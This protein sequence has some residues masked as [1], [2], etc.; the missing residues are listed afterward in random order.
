MK[1]W[2]FSIMAIVAIQIQAADVVYKYLVVTSADGTQ[3]SLSSSGLK[4]S[5][6]DGKMIAANGTDSKS[7]TLTELAR[8]QFAETA[9]TTAIDRSL[10]ADSQRVEAYT[11]SGMFAGSSDSM[12]SLQSQ[13][14]SGVY[15]VKQN[16]KSSKIIVR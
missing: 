10:T 3:T 16:N 4:L 2:I 5:F 15:V 11:L 8:M 12:S 6:A 1:K 9:S 13:L 7:F 14:R